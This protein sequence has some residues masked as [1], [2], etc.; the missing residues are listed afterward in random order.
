MLAGGGWLRVR[1]GRPG[2]LLLRHHSPGLP[3]EWMPPCSGSHSFGRAHLPMSAW[4]SRSRQ[5]TFMC[6]G[7]LIT[8]LIAD[9][10]AIKRRSGLD[11]N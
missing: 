11:W 3:G 5:S 10:A 7:A 6:G 9:T 8:L 4:F 1:L 2:V